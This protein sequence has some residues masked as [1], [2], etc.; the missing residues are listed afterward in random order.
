MNGLGC[1]L[2]LVSSRYYYTKSRLEIPINVKSPVPEPVHGDPVTQGLK[3]SPY[4]GVSF[5]D[6]LLD[7]RLPFD[8]GG[9][10]EPITQAKRC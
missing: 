5:I 2:L 10:V 3:L 4:L 6:P 7:P 8:V 9:G 1:P